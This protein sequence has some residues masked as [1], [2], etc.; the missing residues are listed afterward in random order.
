MTGTLQT[1]KL[2]D[3]EYYYVVL[4]LYEDGKRKPKW[5]PTGLHI[6]GNK[7]RAEQILRDTIQE[8]ERRYTS[9]KSS[10]RF[11]DWV[12]EWL[13]IAKK[14]V[15]IVTYEG[16]LATAERHVLPYFDTT[17]TT[18]GDITRPVLQA[19]VDE[20]SAHGR[21]DGK[22]GLSPASIRHIRNILYQFLKT[23]VYDGWILANPSEGLRLP[24]QQASE[25][26]FYTADQ[27]THLFALIKDEPLY[28]FI[29]ITAVYGLR[30]SEALGL[31]W[32]SVDFEAST[33]TVKHTVVKQTSLVAKDKTKNAS[34][35]RTFPLSLE[36]KNL[37]LDLQ[38]RERENRFLFGETY[39]Y[40]PY[41][42]KWPDGRPYAPH[43]VSHK[44]QKLLT[45]NNL[46]HIR[47]HDLRHSCASLLIA[48][49]FGLKDVQ[50]ILS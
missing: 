28:P 41:I 4:Y 18:L 39:Q 15:D 8:Y 37:F 33:L 38:Q 26:S 20:K 45:S 14:R 43:Y 19:F 34:S 31:Q 36:D 22:G 40:S 5:I 9:K 46:P 27:L 29:R 47:F 24:K 42:F 49:G 12:R 13:E 3:G 44:F 21:L 11:S 1:K 30:K 16:Y 10:L 48:Q 35:R 25:F 7:R 6:K 2:K 32:D 17:D 50:E 23:A